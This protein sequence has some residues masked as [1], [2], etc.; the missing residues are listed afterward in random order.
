[1]Q[2]RPDAHELLEALARYLRDELLPDAPPDHRFRVRVAANVAE[3]LARETRPLAPDRAGLRALARAIRAGEY[4]DGLPELAAA[5][6]E[7]VRGKLTV[8]HPG[9]DALADDGRE[10]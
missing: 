5:L 3:M 2:D 6:R 1:M 8:A 10:A 9:W 4:D 7:E